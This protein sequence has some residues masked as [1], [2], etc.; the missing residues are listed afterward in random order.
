MVTLGSEK[1]A[2]CISCH[3]SSQL[4]DIYKPDNP[5]STIN[6]KNIEATCKNC[7]KKINKYFVKIA[8]HPNLE[9]PHNPVLFILNNLVLRM[10]LYGTV[11]GLMGLLFLETFRRRRDGASMQL[12]S[13]TSWRRKKRKKKK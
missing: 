10:I 8:V 9:D 12:K 6:E 13:G 7:H 11:F 1:A 2:D 4:H 5:K 3:A